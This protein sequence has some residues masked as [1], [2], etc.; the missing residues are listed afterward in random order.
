TAPFPVPPGRS[1]RRCA[2][3]AAA[4][5]A[6]ARCPGACPW[7]GPSC[8]PPARPRA[9]PRQRRAADPKRARSRRCPDRLRCGSWRSSSLHVGG[10]VLE[11]LTEGRDCIGIHLVGALTLDH[12]D[13]LGDRVHVGG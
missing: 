11:H 13:E 8:T 9:P 5:L 12:V 3:R 4:A 7:T 10:E 2:A 6:R 1:L